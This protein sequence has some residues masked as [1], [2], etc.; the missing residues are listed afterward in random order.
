MPSFEYEATTATGERVRNVAFG[1][2]LQEVVIRLTGQG[3]QVTN[4]SDAYSQSDPLKQA[5]VATAPA[6]TA[7][8]QAAPTAEQQQYT[9][10]EYARPEYVQPERI[11]DTAPNP[12]I[13]REQPVGVAAPALNMQ[14]VPRA[15]PELGKRNPMLTT[16]F[17]PMILKAPLKDLSFFFRQFGTMTAAGVPMVTTLET[18]GSQ[19]QNIR[20]KRIIYE[21]KNA[22]DAGLPISAIL[23]RYP[24]VFSPLIVSLIRAGEEGGFLAD[25][26]LHVSD[27]LNYDLEIKNMYR[28]ETF[29][30]KVYIGACILIIGLA[31]VILSSLNAPGLYSPLNNI[32]NWFIIA[33]VIIGI[34]LFF[35]VGMAV[36]PIRLGWDQIKLKI[37]YIGKTSHYFAM[38]KFGRAFSALHKGGVP[39]TKSVPLAAD[40]SGNEHVR[41]RI[42]PTLQKIQEGQ[43]ITQTLKE[44]GVFSPIA[45]N[46]MATGETTGN[47]DSM[48]M[49]ASEYY[50]DEGKVRARQMAVAVG[51]FVLL[52]VLCYMGYIVI[53]FWMSYSQQM[54]NMANST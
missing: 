3:L 13:N 8:V 27:Y 29:L 12:E 19:S 9:Q 48:I 37:P 5:N 24:E 50:E 33:P 2:N 54:Q 14:S 10:Q 45:I 15:L 7:P 11:Y 41:S 35:T 18:L 1:N 49:K 38:A 46:M 42:Y 39:I 25:A 32:E 16:V 40:A 23:Q 44:T 22:V 31:N 6:P 52:A 34:F 26:A 30:P 4:I 28:R 47:L 53:S 36:Y 17:G 20:L 51:V 21:M 43:S